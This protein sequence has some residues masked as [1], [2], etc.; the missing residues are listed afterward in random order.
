MAA[1]TGN[2]PARYLYGFAAAH[3]EVGRSHAA[4]LHAGVRHTWRT[5]ALRGTSQRAAKQP[6][7]PLQSSSFAQTPASGLMGGSAPSPPSVI[8]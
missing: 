3:F 5:H 8:T 7:V 6:I 1:P 2:C 4:E